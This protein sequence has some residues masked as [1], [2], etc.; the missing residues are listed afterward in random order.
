MSAPGDRPRL[1][2]ALALG[3]GYGVGTL[4]P[5]SRLPRTATSLA[6]G[7][8]AS[9]VAVAA[10]LRAFTDS[11]SAEGGEAGEKAA[12][13]VSAPAPRGRRA[14]AAVGVVG[15]VGGVVGAST[16]VGLAVDAAMESA[17]TRRGVRRPRVVMAVG[18]AVL[19]TALEWDDDDGRSRAA[20]GAEAPGS[21]GS[22]AAP[23]A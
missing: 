17:L 12:G 7:G 1:A 9:A 4:P 3:A 10:G 22:A 5:A 8:L 18:A 2:R 20:G 13:G 14:L 23:V 6:V 16:W 19:G 21:P 11:P 15:L